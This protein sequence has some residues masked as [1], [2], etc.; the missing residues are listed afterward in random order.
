MK[1]RPAPAPAVE[2]ALA[3]IAY[4]AKPSP[5][6]SPTTTHAIEN[7]PFGVAP[8]QLWSRE[9]STARTGAARHTASAAMT[10]TEMRFMVGRYAKGQ[11]QPAPRIM[12]TY[13]AIEALQRTPGA[14]EAPGGNVRIQP[15]IVHHAVE[16][17]L[18][19]RQA[20]RDAR[21][22]RRGGRD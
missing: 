10:G 7:W 17:L 2:S 8:S 19:R 1:T 4:S 13:S 9:R 21:R 18:L 6:M 3:P 15:A 14:Q 22:R 12:P 20:A 11:P 5:S 16:Q